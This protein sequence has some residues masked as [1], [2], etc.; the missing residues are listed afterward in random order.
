MSPAR[1]AYTQ[2][3]GREKKKREDKDKDEQTK[4]IPQGV[5]LDKHH[6]QDWDT[7]TLNQALYHE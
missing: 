6:R 7:Y 1:C 4:E 5:K 2:S 3:T